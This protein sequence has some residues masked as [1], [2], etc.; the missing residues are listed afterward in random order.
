MVGAACSLIERDGLLYASK[1]ACY[2]VC[3]VKAVSAAG[4]QQVT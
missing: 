4:L 2:S 3:D 1:E